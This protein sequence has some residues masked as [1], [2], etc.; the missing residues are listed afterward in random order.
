VGPPG[1]ASVFDATFISKTTWAHASTVV[2]Q[3]VVPLRLSA[4]TSR[5]LRADQVESPPAA[6]QVWFEPGDSQANAPQPILV[7]HGTLRLGS[8][9]LD[10][11]SNDSSDA[12]FRMFARGGRLLIR[13]HCTNLLDRDG[14]M[15]SAATD[16]FRLGEALHIPGGVFE[17]WF[18]VQPG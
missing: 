12:L 10:W 11:A 17:S 16:A 18:F 9:N 15:L 4:S 2:A 14:N 6:V 13:I 5:P 8:S 1:P 7:V 3:S